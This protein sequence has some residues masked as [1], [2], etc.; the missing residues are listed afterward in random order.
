MCGGI[1]LPNVFQTLH[2]FSDRATVATIMMVAYGH[3]GISYQDHVLSLS[4]THFSWLTHQEIEG[5]MVKLYL[6]LKFM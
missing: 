5:E 4:H 3:E 1:V 6:L 2:E